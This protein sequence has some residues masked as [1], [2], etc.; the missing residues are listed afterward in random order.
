[1]SF[2]GTPLGQGRRLDHDTFL[3]K[4]Q[5][6]SR[7]PS[8]G[9][10]YPANG[11]RSP[12]KLHPEKWAYKDTSVNV[13]NAFHLAAEDM[14]PNQAWAAGPSRTNVPRSTSVEY[15][16]QLRQTSGRGLV[17]PPSRFAKPPSH[18]RSNGTIS[19]SEN[20]F[21]REKS[22]FDQIAEKIHQSIPGPLQFIVRQ[23]E[24]EDST[25]YEYSMEE[26][27]YQSQ[28]KRQTH[29]RNR[30]STDNKAYKPSQSDLEESDED[31]DDDDRTRRRKKKKK[32][33]GGGLLTTLPVIGQDKRRKR[34]KKNVTTGED[35]ESEPEQDQQQQ[36]PPNTAPPP[37]AASR[38]PSLTSQRP[39]SVAPQR[40]PSMPRAQSLH[41]ADVSE[42]LEA[43]VR[44]LDSIAEMDESTLPD[45]TAEEELYPSRPRG[46]IISVLAGR[47]VHILIQVPFV[48]LGRIVG[49]LADLIIR[50]CRKTW[51]LA[52]P[53]PIVML[54]VS[55]I[56]YNG[57]GM[58]SSLFHRGKYVP[59]QTA[60][61][62]ISELSNRLLS[63]ESA[64]LALADREEVFRKLRALETRVDNADLRVG[65]TESSLR[66][67]AGSD[68]QNIRKEL[69]EL[70]AKLT[71]EMERERAV[72]VPS[73]EDEEARSRLKALEERVGGVEGGVKE[74]LDASKKAAN[75]PGW[76]KKQPGSAPSA[77]AVREV[78][79][80]MYSG[81]MLERV[82]HALFTGGGAIVPTLTS[83]SLRQSLA[84]PRSGFSSVISW[85]SGGHGD[86]VE[87]SPVIA[88]TP[89]VQPGQCW[90]FAA[91][92]GRLGV[93]LRLPA[94]I[95]EVTIEHAAGSIAYDL[96]SAPRDMEVW[97][98]I[99]GADNAEKWAAVTAAREAAGAPADE[100]EAAFAAE[101]ARLTHGALYV[102]IAQFAYD[103]EAGRYAQSFAVAEDVR[104]Q[105]MDFGIVMLRVLSNWGHPGH[106][107]LYRFRV[108]GETA[109]TI[110]PPSVP[111][112]EADGEP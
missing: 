83:P 1:M 40:G 66:M 41:P 101:M 45:P 19:Q 8:T 4:P 93:K 23:R 96:R 97:A 62:D 53:W 16:N 39:P 20:S 103:I 73:T 102:R 100:G 92:E 87:R 71:A 109:A 3:N 57:L 25:S 18:D 56:L 99:D 7:P 26:R 82:D 75:A 38:P 54:G 91:G 48:W 46:S 79:L 21:A 5:A 80:R 67:V 36:Q 50:I 12:P 31:F 47:L 85:I 74:A 10:S 70:G 104:E 32:E 112:D 43:G 63:I 76:W 33:T 106:T 2:A 72:P 28:T 110:E 22:P 37:R 14:N 65:Q 88:L 98:L 111:G 108:H 35:E 68:L 84:A 17:P 9:Y 89:G 95:D 64:V 6:K 27:D 77:D 105:G 58:F 11:S 55:L 49:T 42:E 13:A 15:E 51:L 30:I 86:I 81:D 61:A 90:A 44:S 29:R 34:K 60:P 24:P 78:V 59:P 69:Q 52:G 94:R 107:C